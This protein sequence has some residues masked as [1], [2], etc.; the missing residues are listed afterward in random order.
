M[1]YKNILCIGLIFVHLFL[2]GTGSCY[3]L[4]TLVAKK[5]DQAPVIDGKSNDKVWNHTKAIVTH[6]NVAV[7]DITLKALY[8]TDKV[9]FLITYPDKNESVTHRSWEWNKKNEEYM[10]GRDREDTLVL[11]WNLEKKPVDLSVYADNFYTA[12]IWYWKSNRT[13]P[14]G[15][16][17]D[18][19]HCL[20]KQKLKKSSEVRSKKGNIMYLQ[21][22]GDP[23]KSSYRS[24][25]PIK[26]EG[27]VI[28]RYK[29]HQ[30][31]LSRADIKAKGV[32]KAG[33]WIIEFSRNLQ[34]N[35][36]EHDIQLVPMQTYLFGVSRYEIAGRDPDDS[37]QPMFGS[38]DVAEKL[39]FEFSH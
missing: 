9:F 21:R 23:G 30:P 33:K 11:K 31:S 19:F 20:S 10:Q 17:D 13:N 29:L 15:Y 32:W 26:Y 16:A 35:D 24:T 25:L 8:T 12:D 5:V 39:Y 6:D 3:A 1:C 27:D 34:T 36:K 28:N 37:E 4:Q 7:I 14:I 38:G 22:I 18:K 2:L